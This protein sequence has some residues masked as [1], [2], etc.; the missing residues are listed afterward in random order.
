MAARASVGTT[1]NVAVEILDLRH[2]SSSDLRPLLDEEVTS[3]GG[4]LAWDYRSSSEMILR[5]VDAKILPGYAAIERGSIIGYSF[6]VYEGSKGV[7]GDLFVSPSRHDS[8]EI[9]I[10]MLEHVI[11]TLQ[12]SPGVHRIEA[13][14]LT[15]STG[16]L[17][18]PFLSN[19]FQRHHRLFLSLQ[20]SGSNA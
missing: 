18:E 6:F 19:G 2:F 1:H 20:L 16:E 4:L 5:Y 9:E 8:R 17:S 14:L 10:R 7:I 13:Q 3:W 11:E 15:H 12:E